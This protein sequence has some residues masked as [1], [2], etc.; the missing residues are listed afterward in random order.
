MEMRWVCSSCYAR[1]QMWVYLERRFITSFQ[2]VTFESTEHVLICLDNDEQIYPAGR[3]VPQTSGES[4]VGL[5]EWIADGSASIDNTDIV[6][7][8][9]FGITHFPSPKI[10]PSCQLES[11]AWCTSEL[12]QYAESSG[13]KE[14]GPLWCRAGSNRQ[15]EQISIWVGKGRPKVTVC[16]FLRT[17]FIR[18]P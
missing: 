5:P 6:L 7:W 14:S 10:F 2:F 9:T 15:D 1:Y 12:L 16:S 13:G 17:C 4:S 3:H 18:L 8:H 11:S